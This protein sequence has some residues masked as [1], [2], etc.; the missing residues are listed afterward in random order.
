L[1]SSSCLTDELLHADG[2]AAF[3]ELLDVASGIMATTEQVLRDAETGLTAKE[4]DVLAL[5][6]ALGPSRP[7]EILRRIVLTNRAQTLSSILD[8]L[9]ARGL[10]T[11]S[12]HR[13]DGRSIL[14][15]L[16]DEGRRTVEWVFPL[17][18]RAVIR[19]F[20]SAYTDSD[21]TTLRALL[22]RNRPG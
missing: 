14:V 18:A 1:R 13:Q 17:I 6:H 22:A 15:S 11:R 19:P 5:T 21:I 9:E 20:T 7:T 16:T 10:V 8:R 12:P 4:W 3:L 2:V